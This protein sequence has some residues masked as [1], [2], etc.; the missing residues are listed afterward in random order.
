MNNFRQR[1]RYVLDED[2]PQ[3]QHR[4]LVMSLYLSYLAFV[5]GLWLTGSV[6][7][8]PN[9]LLPSAFVQYIENLRV[10]ILVTPLLILFACYFKLRYSTSAIMASPEKY[11]D[12]RQK[13]VRDQAHRYA[14]KI[15]KALC[16]LVPICLFL[17]SLLRSGSVSVVREGSPFSS[18]N[19]NIA[20]VFWL[21]DAPR[22]WI[23]HTYILGTMHAD[24]VPT[25][26]VAWP[27]DLTSLALYYGVF[28][29]GV[30]LVVSTLPMS[31]IAWKERE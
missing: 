7:E 24:R 1:A 20:R 9:A 18:P 26:P 10:V 13:M 3:A 4:R 12:E 5:V 11:L 15:I 23:L 21:Y 16:L 30:F 17:Q 14:Y 6:L 28:L 27:N 8:Y 19:L 29:L 22:G 2:S 25:A 31:I